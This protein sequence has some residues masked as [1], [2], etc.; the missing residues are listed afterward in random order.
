MRVTLWAPFLDLTKYRNKNQN[1]RNDRKTRHGETS[2]NSYT[3]SYPLA[4]LEQ[5]PFCGVHFLCTLEFHLSGRQA[6]GNVQRRALP[7]DWP[8]TGHVYRGVPQ[9]Q[10]PLQGSARVRAVQAVRAVPSPSGSAAGAAD[11]RASLR[12]LRRPPMKLLVTLDHSIGS[13]GSHSRALSR[14]LAHW[15]PPATLGPSSGPLPENG[16]QGVPCLT[17]QG[18]CGLPQTIQQALVHFD[19]PGFSVLSFEASLSKAGARPACEGSPVL[20]AG[21]RTHCDAPISCSM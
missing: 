19:V 20:N 18:C 3:L 21:H 2:P 10:R 8:H 14:T 7:R 15:P 12:P 17:S 16:R 11:L 1:E 6:H 9:V 13:I 4:A 5:K